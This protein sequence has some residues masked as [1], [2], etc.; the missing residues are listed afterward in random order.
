MMVW[1]GVLNESE[2]NLRYIKFVLSTWVKHSKR[3]ADHMPPSI[4]EVKNELNYILPLISIME[5]S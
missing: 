3:E 1:I 5:S 4:A 2:F